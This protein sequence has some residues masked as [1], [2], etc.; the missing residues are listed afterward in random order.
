MI[1]GLVAPVEERDAAR[2]SGYT[3]HD[4]GT[5][6]YRERVDGVAYFRISRQMEMH[7]EEAMS[8]H[9]Q[10]KAKSK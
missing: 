10:R 1:P 8:K 4:W 2:H 9:M 3:W 7:K 6:P 5:L